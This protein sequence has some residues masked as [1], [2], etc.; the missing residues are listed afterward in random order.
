MQKIIFFTPIPET[1]KLATMVSDKH[2]NDLI[3]EG[4][5]PAD[6]KYVVETLDVNNKEQHATIY[7]IEYM[8]FD[9]PTNPQQIVLNKDM[10]A[11]ALIE[12]IRTKRSEQ[13]AD[14]DG[15]Q[16]RASIMT[17]T[18]LVDEIE[19]DKEILRNLPATINFDSKGTI[20]DMYSIAPVELFINYNEKYGPKF[21]K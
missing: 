9:N 3:Q 14:L 7:H 10:L 6:S 16:F 20:K 18:N 2:P 1:G 13:L 21:K 12:D 15:L 5:I 19:A 11:V 4:I 8:R 17:N